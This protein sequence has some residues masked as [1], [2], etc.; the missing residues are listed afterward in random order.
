MNLKN[1]SE[2]PSVHAY[3]NLNIYCVDFIHGIKCFPRK[4]HIL[5]FIW[6]TTAAVY[7]TVLIYYLYSAGTGGHI[8]L[9]YSTTAWHIRFNVNYFTLSIEGNQGKGCKGFPESTCCSSA[10]RQIHK[11]TPGSRLVQLVFSCLISSVVLYSQLLLCR[12][13]SG[14]TGPP[15]MFLFPMIHF[16][17]VHLKIFKILYW[18]YE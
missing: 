16:C 8:P 13:I 3:V 1:D 6:I 15:T 9:L 7:H 2:Q 12:V 11:S 14:R 5:S 17:S 10:F 18:N 4:S